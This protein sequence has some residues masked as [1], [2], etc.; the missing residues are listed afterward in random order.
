MVLIAA[1]RA[2]L[3]TTSLVT[4]SLVTTSMVTSAVI[5][6][7]QRRSG[8]HKAGAQGSKSNARPH[9]ILLRIRAVCLAQAAQ[10]WRGR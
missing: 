5:P 4:T 7:G 10:L 6:V 8:Q 1:M 3:V 2:S 9:A